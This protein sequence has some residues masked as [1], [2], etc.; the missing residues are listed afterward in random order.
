MGIHFIVA[1]VAMKSNGKALWKRKVDLY[2]SWGWSDEQIIA[3]FTMF[4]SCM[5]A[6][7]GKISAF[8]DF[9]VNN[10]G[11]EVAEHPYL[12][13]YSLEKRVLPR[14]PVI[15]FLLSNGLLGKKVSRMSTMFSCPE[16][17]FTRMCL[18]SLKNEPQLLK[19]F[20]E[21]FDLCNVREGSA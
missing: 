14:A 6:S 19:L 9:L 3:A 21:K 16:K 18:T 17:V 11:W 20:M 7:E 5:V 1:I 4:P 2:K 15:Q 13:S 10:M 12:I 8:M